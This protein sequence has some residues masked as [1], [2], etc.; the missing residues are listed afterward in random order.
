M[1][2]DEC[3]HKGSPRYSKLRLPTWNIGTLLGKGINLVDT[4]IRM[5][6]NTCLQETKWVEKNL[7]KLKIQEHIWFT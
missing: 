5:R 7:K 2:L 6:N 3:G 4:M 1:F